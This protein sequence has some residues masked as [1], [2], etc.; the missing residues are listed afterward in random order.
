MRRVALL[1]AFAAVLAVG[2]GPAESR[3]PLDYALVARNVLPPGQSG[4]LLFP[5]TTRDQLALY[6]GLTPKRSA[7]GAADVMRY[8]KSARFGPDGRPTRTIRPRRGVRIVRDRWDVPHVYGRTRADVMFGAGWATAEDRG[9]LMN[10]LRGPGRISALDVPGLNAFALATSARD[11]EPSAQTEAFLARQL[12][13]LRRAGPSGRQVLRDVDAY[14]A[15]INAYFR[16]VGHGIVWSRND[17]IAVASLIGAVFGSGGG[18]EA[19]S[20][21]LL[22]A[23]RDHL[24]AARGERVWNDLRLLDDPESP[25]A[26]P[27]RFPYGAPAAGRSASVVL[28]AGS[29]GAPESARLRMSNALLIGRSRSVGAARSSSP[30]RRRG[31]P[32]RRS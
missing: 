19:R 30:A 22:D 31:T 23:L 14:L 28:D 3:E 8:F 17:V 24:G 7:V 13:L 26:V 29:F 27:G 16:G 25:V 15:G 18:D 1:A 21:Q 20:A 11:F 4:S 32:S 10:L 12:E 6:D 9:L 5:R 2:L